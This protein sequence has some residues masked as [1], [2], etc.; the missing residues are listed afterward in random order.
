MRANIIILV[1][2][3][4]FPLLNAIAGGADCASEAGKQQADMLVQW[5][6]NV[7]PATHP[8]CHAANRCDLIIDEIKRGCAFLQ[9]D[10][11]AP[12]YCQLTYRHEPEITNPE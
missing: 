5:C 1:I 6:R 10:K 3:L 9:H 11:H 2:G 4:G 7:S 8:P 12:Y